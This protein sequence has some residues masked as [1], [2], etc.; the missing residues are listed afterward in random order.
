MSGDRYLLKITSGSADICGLHASEADPHILAGLPNLVVG[1]EYVTDLSRNVATETVTFVQ[2]T[3]ASTVNVF[4]TRSRIK[5]QRALSP[6]SYEIGIYAEGDADGRSSSING[7]I[8]ATNC[9]MAVPFARWSSFIGSYETVSLDGR[10][11]NG[12]ERRMGNVVARNIQTARGQVHQIVEFP[13]LTVSSGST[14]S[15]VEMGPIEG[16]GVSRRE[17]VG[18]SERLV[19]EYDGELTEQGT[20]H[21]VQFYMDLMELS[22]RRLEINHRFHIV[23]SSTPASTHRI[24]L[25]RF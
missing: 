16:R 2:S 13:L 3:A 18:T 10:A 25:Q 19:Y 4:A 20:T 9:E 5:L 21:R 6:S 14:S 24:V 15:T 1:S 12:I 22:G 23:G 11:L 17:M 8:E 7:I